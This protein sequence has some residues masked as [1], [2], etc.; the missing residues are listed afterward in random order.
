MSAGRGP[1]YAAPTGFTPHRRT[2]AEY[3]DDP[4]LPAAERA[5][6]Y[7]DLERF[8]RW[9]FQYG[10]LRTGVLRLLEGVTTRPVEILELGAGTGHT[11]RRLAA[12]LARRGIE[13]RLHLTDRSLEFL[14]A[15][16]GSGER[17]SRLDWLADPLPVADVV[18]ANLVLH[19]FETAAAVTALARAATAARIGGVIYDLHRRALAFHLLKWTLPLIARSPITLADGLISVQ[20]AFTPRE[21]LELARAAGIERPE[22]STHGLL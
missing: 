21:L 17:V 1:A 9:P 3:L 8:D 7:R 14:E 18:V 13:A 5:L 6:S 20:Q 19:H 2:A 11:G 12:S 15:A 16:P 22:V 10:P 4:S